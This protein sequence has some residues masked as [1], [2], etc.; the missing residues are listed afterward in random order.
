MAMFVPII[1]AVDADTPTEKKIKEIKKEIV[2]NKNNRLEYKYL[3]DEQKEFI[4][5]GDDI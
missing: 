4:F 1:I 5:V 2:D 3:Q